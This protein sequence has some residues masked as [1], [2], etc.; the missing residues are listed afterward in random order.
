MKKRCLD[1]SCQ[2]FAVRSVHFSPL[3]PRAG[4]KCTFGLYACMRGKSLI[5][6]L[7]RAS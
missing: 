2:S 5:G 1:C 6:L 3:A 4:G 7:E